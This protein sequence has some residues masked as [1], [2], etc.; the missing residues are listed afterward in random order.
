DIGD[1]AIIH[2]SH[3]IASGWTKDDVRKELRISRR[4]LDAM[5]THCPEF[6]D[7]LSRYETES[8]AAVVDGTK[9]RRAEDEE[10]WEAS[11][12]PVQIGDDI[13]KP[14]ELW[15]RQEDQLRR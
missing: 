2:A 7:R 3:L 4:V 10:L 12:P 13:D 8:V 6:L 5:F 11:I 9:R 1:D 14:T 15:R